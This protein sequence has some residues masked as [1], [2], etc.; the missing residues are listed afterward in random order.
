MMLGSGLIE[1][2]SKRSVLEKFDYGA[3]DLAV[4]NLHIGEWVGLMKVQHLR[5][6]ISDAALL[7]ASEGAN[8]EVELRASRKFADSRLNA[9]VAAAH[10]EIVAGYPKG[11]LFWILSSRRWRS[12]RS[13]VMR[14][15][16][17]C[18]DLRRRTRHSAYEEL[19]VGRREDGR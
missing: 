3:G 8:G 15:A 5:L 12:R 19:R 17:S 2:G 18:A 14:K 11:R 4:C 7:A 1:W 6:C 16:S 13:M 9:V 10:A